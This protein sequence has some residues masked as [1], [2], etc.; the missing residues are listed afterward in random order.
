[1]LVA[2]GARHAAPQAERARGHESGH[3]LLVRGA[4][5]CRAGRAGPTVEA[6]H[7]I[8]VIRGGALLLQC[9]KRSGVGARGRLPKTER[10]RKQHV[11]TRVQSQNSG[12]GISASAECEDNY[13]DRE[14]N[15]KIFL[16]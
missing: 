10:E 14:A 16:Y 12:A 7:L 11:T 5:A 2:A 8:G 13:S 1:M 6:V 9:I 15:G 4:A 3:G